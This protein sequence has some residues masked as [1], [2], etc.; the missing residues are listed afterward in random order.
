MSLSEKNSFLRG[1]NMSVVFLF[2]QSVLWKKDK[3]GKGIERIIHPQ[4]HSPSNAHTTSMQ[5]EFHLLS[6]WAVV[7]NPVIDPQYPLGTLGVVLGAIL[8][9]TVLCSGQQTWSQLQWGLSFKPTRMEQQVAKGSEANASSTT[10]SMAVLPCCTCFHSIEILSEGIVHG[11]VVAAAWPG[12]KIHRWS[13][14]IQ[15]P[16]FGHRTAKTKKSTMSISIVHSTPDIPWQQ[17]LWPA[18]SWI[19]SANTLIIVGAEEAHSI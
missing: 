4:H 3:R 1:S 2:Q 16:I 18:I 5:T 8:S 7:L 15:G 17:Q 6:T 19:D 9:A 13:Q 10:D 14:Q 11:I 12:W